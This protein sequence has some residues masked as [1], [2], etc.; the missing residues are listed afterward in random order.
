MTRLQVNFDLAVEVRY[1]GTL[2]VVGMAE[3]H[4]KDTF[5]TVVTF[6]LSYRDENPLAQY[7][8]HASMGSIPSLLFSIF[9]EEGVQTMKS[10]ASDEQF[11]IFTREV[12]GEL[13]DPRNFLHTTAEKLLRELQGIEDRQL[14]LEELDAD[15]AWAEKQILHGTSEPIP[16][17]KRPRH[18]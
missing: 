13:R 1:V 5:S 2:A 17:F 10:P 8:W 14:C 18:I 9:V 7:F 11:L 3:K 4:K 16:N 6:L 12:E 15:M